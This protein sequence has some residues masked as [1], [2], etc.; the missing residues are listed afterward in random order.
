MSSVLPL[1]LGIV[2]ASERL[3]LS[4][5]RSAD[6]NSSGALFAI[7]PAIETQD[8][9]PYF[10]RSANSVVIPV[11]VLQNITPAD[12]ATAPLSAAA[13]YSAVASSADQSGQAAV[14]NVNAAA[15][16]ASLPPL[17]SGNMVESSQAAYAYAQMMQAWQETKSPRPA[18]VRLLSK[19]KP[20]ERR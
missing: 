4:A 15:A 5:G 9:E 19:S 17:M 16:E 8:A 10:P 20:R 11:D 12:A 1:A 6:K 18:A 3:L 13:V 7:R 14:A 2:A